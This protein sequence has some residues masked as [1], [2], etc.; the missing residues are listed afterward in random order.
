MEVFRSQ[1]K[2]SVRGKDELLPE[3][4]QAI[5]QVVRQAYTDAPYL[6][7][8]SGKGQLCQCNCRYRYPL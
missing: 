7:G 2:S 1:L 4:V 3:L 6:L 5:Q 8:S